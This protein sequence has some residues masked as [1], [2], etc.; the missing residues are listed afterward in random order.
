[1]SG[2]IASHSAYNG[3]GTQGLAVTNVMPAMD[4]TGNPTSDVMSVFWNKNDTTKQLTYGSAMVEVPSSG[5]STLNFG[6]SRLF[7]VNNDID[8]LGDMFLEI[9]ATLPGYVL[10][11]GSA[12]QVGD[13][14]GITSS[15]LLKPFALQSLI[16]R[17]EIQ[18]GTQ[19]WQTIEKEDLRVVNST[20]LGADA[21]AESSIMSTPSILETHGSNNNCGAT[22][23]ENGTTVAP[24]TT[25]LVIPSLTK[26][27]GPAFGK[28]SNHTEDGYPLVAAPQQ[29]VRIKVQFVETFPA[30]LNYTTATPAT[31]LVQASGATVTTTP[32]MIKESVPYT[33]SIAVAGA[34]TTV[35]AADRPGEGV[36]AITGSGGTINSCKLYAK[37]QIMCND[38]RAQI[39][40][41]PEGMP[42]RLKMTQNAYTTDLGQSDVKTIELDH[43]S[44][45]ASHLIITGEV[46]L[47]IKLVHAELK[48]NSSSYSSKLPGVLLDYATADTLGLFT[49]K[50]IYQTGD[51][52]G[53][54]PTL[55][56]EEF[57][58]GTYV[59]PLASTAYSGSS[60]PL[61]RFDSIRLELKFSARPLT[62]VN[63]FINVT[64]VGETTALFKG[65][66]ASLAMY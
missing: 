31:A 45:Y 21:F 41:M 35:N 51:V 25:W 44:L 2:A 48:L 17:V 12:G 1:M 53:A 56:V 13:H 57:G 23:A 34:N 62:S 19:V 16:E 58:M 61:N 7:T 50:Y 46:G 32:V 42:R 63:T 24:A 20:E 55:E 40:A 22:V 8:C 15:I 33:G 28:F 27:L 30:T 60:V 11:G 49:N 9:S 26:T 47:G 59:F 18:V 64:C 37:Q 3:S 6:G 38:E 54:A 43:F 10:N 39:L 65:G 52:P 36:F 14:A 5:S 29:P 4:A 66:A